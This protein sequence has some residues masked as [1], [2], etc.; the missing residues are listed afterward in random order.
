MLF[1]SFLI[2]T[3]WAP[4]L[5]CVTSCTLGSDNG[6]F[7]L[8]GGQVGTRPGPLG[9][10]DPVRVTGC[11]IYFPA[12]AGGGVTTSLRCAQAPSPNAVTKTATIMISF[13]NFNLSPSFRR[14]LLRSV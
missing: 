2:S 8:R 10:I 9:E 7:R 6:F 3:K 11:S 5:L 12:G 4:A 14:R 1:F 13:K